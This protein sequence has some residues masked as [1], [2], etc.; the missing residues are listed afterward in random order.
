MGTQQKSPV[1]NDLNEAPAQEPSRVH[2]IETCQEAETEKS[3]VNQAMPAG[4]VTQAMAPTK[5][6]DE[7]NKPLDIPENQ[8]LVA[9]K[10]RE[11]RESNIDRFGSSQ[12]PTPVVKE[13]YKQC[14]GGLSTV[15]A[16]NEGRKTPN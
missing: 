8:E 3:V 11:F 5:T 13:V 4:P 10:I 2:M 7:L 14:A 15:S 12:V 6:F 16:E 1:K 9:R